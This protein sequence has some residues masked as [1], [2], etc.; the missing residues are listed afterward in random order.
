MSY[1]IK[2]KTLIFCRKILLNVYTKIEVFEVGNSVECC[3][4]NKI[5]EN[6]SI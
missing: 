4:I 3:D 5:K 2:F 6:G 1:V